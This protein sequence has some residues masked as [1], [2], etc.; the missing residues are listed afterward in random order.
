MTDNN[1]VSDF[2]IKALFMKRWSPRAFTSEVMPETDLLTMLEAARWA[3]SSSNLQPWRFSY[4]LRDTPDWDRYVGF[5]MEGNQIWAKNA[6]ALVI[7]ISKT[8]NA[9]SPEA[10]ARFNPSHSFDTGA[11]S[12]AFQLQAIKLGYHAHPMGGIFKDKIKLELAI[13]QEGYGVEAA[14]AVGKIAPKETLPEPL[15]SREL[16]SLRR[17]LSEIISKGGFKP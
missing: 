6:G 7:A 2:P 11:A 14:I 4:A 8:H 1:R 3:P 12:L 10:E 5:L 9:S 17:P 15:R 13:P 16:P